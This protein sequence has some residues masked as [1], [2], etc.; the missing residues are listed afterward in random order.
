MHGNLP[1]I[2]N[3]VLAFRV[4][5]P[6]LGLLRLGHT[7]DSTTHVG[8]STTR[9]AV[10]PAPLVPVG[11]S[12]LRFPCEGGLIR[13]R[14]CLSCETVLDEHRI[15][16]HAA[17]PRTQT[18]PLDRL[19]PTFPSPPVPLWFADRVVPFRHLEQYAEFHWVG[20][21]DVTVYETFPATLPRVRSPHGH[22]PDRSEA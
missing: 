2:A 5:S 6:V 3:G 12:L 19:E 14:A 1:P 16:E 7:D 18:F 11:A 4:Q 13:E 10:N 9:C 8:R 17:F 15:F 20:R 21:G 22:Q